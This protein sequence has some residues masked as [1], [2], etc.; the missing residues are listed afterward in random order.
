MSR[1]RSHKCR[2]DRQHINSIIDHGHCRV[3]ELLVYVEANRVNVRIA[4]DIAHLEDTARMALAAGHSEQW[5]LILSGAQR[6][7]D[8]LEMVRG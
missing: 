2:T 1:E 8:A 6:L 4:R 7:I 3:C 5:K